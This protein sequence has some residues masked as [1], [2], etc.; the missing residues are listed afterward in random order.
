MIRF[1]VKPLVWLEIEKSIP[2]HDDAIFNVLS[3]TKVLENNST[4]WTGKVRGSL[5]RLDDADGEFL[6]EILTTQETANKLYPLDEQ[7]NL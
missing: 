5:V 3:F 7:R 1:H 2:I 6:T 4:L